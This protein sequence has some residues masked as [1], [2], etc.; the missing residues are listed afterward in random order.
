[1]VVW[2]GVVRGV[3]AVAARRW[4]GEVGSFSGRVGWRRTC[5]GCGVDGLVRWVYLGSVVMA[6]CFT[7]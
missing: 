6:Y 2:V 3:L 1:M 7:G 4:F 5:A